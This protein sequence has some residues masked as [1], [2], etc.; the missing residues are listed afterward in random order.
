MEAVSWIRK[1]DLHILTAGIY[2]YTTDQRFV[3]LHPEKSENW[4]LQIKYPQERDAG[5]YECQVNTEPKISMAFHL[6]VIESRARI[7][8]GS[9]IHVQSGSSLRLTCE[10]E[11]G[12][13]DIAQVFWY[14]GSSLID[15]QGLYGEPPVSDIKIATQRGELLK[16]QLTILKVRSHHSGNYTCS[17]TMSAPASVIVHVISEHPA[18]MKKGNRSSSSHTQLHYFQ[19]FL[20]YAFLFL[21][22][23]VHLDVLLRSSSNRSSSTSALSTRAIP[24][25]HLFAS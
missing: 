18:A 19:Y 7:I 25:N 5:V 11:H 21:F 15:P 10:V 20:I 2:T 23:Q 17:P 3:V 9:D 14:H 1:R 8:G 24:D 12:P 22:S 6:T 16:S 4:T 13:H